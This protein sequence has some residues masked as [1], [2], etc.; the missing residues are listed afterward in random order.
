MVGGVVG[1]LRSCGALGGLFERIDSGGTGGLFP[2]SLEERPWNAGW[3][4]S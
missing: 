3:P 1:R 4:L 2:A